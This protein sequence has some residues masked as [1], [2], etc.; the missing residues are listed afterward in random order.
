MDLHNCIR[1]ESC[2]KGYPYRRW[3]EYLLANRFRQYATSFVTS[4]DHHESSYCAERN[5][6][7]RYLS[8]NCSSHFCFLLNPRF[9]SLREDRACP[10]SMSLLDNRNEKENLSSHLQ[11]GPDNYLER[12]TKRGKRFRVSSAK[13]RLSSTYQVSL[14]D[15]FAALQIACPPELADWRISPRLIVLTVYGLVPFI[16]SFTI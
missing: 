1:K 3:R 9:V 10:R 16:S 13:C 6:T 7:K 8:H 11:R 15:C 5:Y 4:R 14:D 2:S 12:N